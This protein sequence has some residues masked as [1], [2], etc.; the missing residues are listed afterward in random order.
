MT[1][2]SGVIILIAMLLVL[3]LIEITA[4]ITFQGSIGLAPL[5][6]ILCAVMTV[7]HLNSY[8]VTGWLDEAYQDGFLARA[9]QVAHSG[10]AATIVYRG[11]AIGLAIGFLILM[12][13]GVNWLVW[14]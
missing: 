14:G 5:L 11:Y 8:I 6:L 10:C 13:Y 4:P 7:W 2:L 9:L 1:I 12:G 3:A